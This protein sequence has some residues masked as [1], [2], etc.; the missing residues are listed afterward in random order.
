MQGLPEARHRLEDLSTAVADPDLRELH[1]TV[2]STVK[3][4]QRELDL[5]Q[6]VRRQLQLRRPVRTWPTPLRPHPSRRRPASP[7]EAGLEVDVDAETT[8][9]PRL[10]DDDLEER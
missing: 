8:A 4:V 2:L 3:R 10:S 6:R 9:L 7:A 1:A 5:E